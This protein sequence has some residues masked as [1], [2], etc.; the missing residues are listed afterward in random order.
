MKDFFKD[1]KSWLIILLLIILIIL[2][3]IPSC[4]K[5]E[6]GNG[7]MPTGNFDIFE[8]GL[9]CYPRG[10]DPDGKEIDVDIEDLPVFDEVEDKY[11]LNKIYVDDKNGD[12]IYQQNLEIF[13]NAAYEYTNK[14]APG[15]SN[16]YNFVVHNSSNGTAAYRF[17]MY[18]NTEYSVN[19]KY[20]LKKNGSYIIGNE[21]N[22]VSADELNV[23]LSN[24]AKDSR[25][26][27]AL[28]WKWFDD[29][30]NDTIAGKNMTS[31]YKLNIRFYIEYTKV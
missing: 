12:Y 1:V 13:N 21:N 31:A 18:E 24:L 25:D 30:E 5:K 7:A 17:L 28:E 11:V 19:L 22:W 23:G 20:R 6:E 27:Y 3:L 15:V 14:I 9:D 26:K 29:D 8:I 16:V 2:L 4:T 10:K